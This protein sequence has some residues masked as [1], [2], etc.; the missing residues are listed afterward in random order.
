MTTSP[1]DPWKVSLH[2]GHS[3][4]FCDHAKGTL[5]ET[6]E[7]AVAFGYH[8]YGVAEHAARVEPRHLYP[9]EAALGWDIDKVQRDFEAYAGAVRRLADEF[10]D[11]LTVL[12]GFEA[13]VIPADRYAGLMLGYRERL[14]FDYMVASAHYV[15]EAFIDYDQA[16]F[17]QAV[18]QYGGLEPLVVA[19]YRGVA[20]MVE[21]LRPEVVAH[22]DVIRKYAGSPCDTPAIRRAVADALEVVR[23]HECILDV[24]TAGYRKGLGMPYPA[25]WIVQL[26]NDMGIPFC[27]GDDSHGPDQVGAG[28]ERAR[29]Y[30]LENRVPTITTLVPGRGSLGSAVGNGALGRRAIS[31]A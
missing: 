9:E 31:L 18:E 12:C 19:Y 20:D 17:D 16:N 28:I 7:A 21:A 5:R 8:V 29:Q 1:R 6:L 4:E 25:P 26:A 23:R 14:G 30:L 10:A 13:E 27:F 2:G 15:G 3:G 11:R 24:N 22:F